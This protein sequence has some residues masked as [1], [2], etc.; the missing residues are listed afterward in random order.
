[1]TQLH[2]TI[3][4]HGPFH[5]A[6]GQPVNGLDRPVDPSVPLPAS[7]LKG[8]MKAEV[9]ERLG[10]DGHFVGQVFG[11]RGVQSPWAWSDARIE[12]QTVDRSA[13]IRIEAGGSGQ[14]DDQFLMLGQHVW[15]P[16]ATFT[17][18]QASWI[19]AERMDDHVLILTAAALSVTALG[20]GRR[21][22]EGW[23]SIGSSREPV[24]TAAQTERLLALRWTGADA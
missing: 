22:G 6:S 1:M 4:F 15:S 18:T 2:F 7:S 10:L 14:A 9:T 17:V 8:L 20:G 11:A 23:V 12:G 16:R 3:T 21:R 19:E 5:V 24:W 13:R